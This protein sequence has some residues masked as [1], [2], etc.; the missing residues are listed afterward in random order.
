[1]TTQKLHNTEHPKVR[2]A[3]GVAAAPLR[4]SIR[5]MLVTGIALGMAGLSSYADPSRTLGA[6]YGFI[7]WQNDQLRTDPATGLTGR[8]GPLRGRDTSVTP[9]LEE[10]GEVPHTD[11]SAEAKGLDAGSRE[12]KMAATAAPACG[13]RMNDCPPSAT[14][15][16]PQDIVSLSGAALHPAGEAARPEP[17]WTGPGETRLSSETSRSASGS[18]GKIGRAHV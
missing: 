3:P 8:Y 2:F 18:A 17:G 16:R 11:R 15:S 10:D 1:M 13:D 14:G 6:Q 12:E 5:I 7:D 4:G 9:V